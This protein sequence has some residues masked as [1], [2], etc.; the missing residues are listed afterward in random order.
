MRTSTFA[1]FWMALSVSS[2]AAAQDALGDGR[3]LDNNLSTTTR[4]NYQRPSL[5]N[6]VRFRNA[7]ATGNAPGGLS[8][9]GDLGYTAP[10]DFRGDLGSDDLFA[11]RR[12]T[13]YSGLAGM[14]IRGT[15]ALQFQFAMTTGGTPPQNLVGSLEFNRGAPSSVTT[16]R[17]PAGINPGL[18]LQP[19]PQM[20]EPESGTLLWSL[21]APSAYETN[22]SY[23]PVLLATGD[24]NDPDQ[25]GVT[26]SEL[27]GIRRTDLLEPQTPAGRIETSLKAEPIDSSYTRLMERLTAE[28]AAQPLNP[29]PGAEED[30]R[31]EWFKR[32]DELRQDLI[33]PLPETAPPSEPAVPAQPGQTQPGQS[34]PVGAQPGQVDPLQPSAAAAGSPRDWTHLT[35]DPVTLRMLRNPGGTP[36]RDFVAPDTQGVY[37]EH[38]KA[39]QRLLASERYFDAEERFTQ[40]LTIRPG[41][42]DAQVA[43]VHAQL[44][45]GM[46]LSAAVNLRTLF[47]EHP[48]L[49]SVRYDAALLPAPAR[50]EYTVS[51][52]REALPDAR[53]DD[54]TLR[55]LRQARAAGLLMAYLGYQTGDMNLFKEGLDAARHAVELVYR[56]APND[57]DAREARVLDLIRQIQG[58]NGSE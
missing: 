47:L 6:E 43:R 56:Q 1:A 18:P 55:A 24:P 28:A 53:R 42:V 9:R 5:A 35:I 12:D 25:V 7:I 19:A 58:E 16:G 21:R 33:A 37:A 15:E 51:R 44:G 23:Q 57:E 2:V 54:P 22:R 32:L 8:F 26:A 49:V 11:F 4:L 41:N 14:G 48:E 20:I 27:R 13:L 46:F 36:S 10:G 45:A 34:Q 31:P 38:M 50:I 30:T 3:A 40:A 29:E 52:L 39:G 17:L